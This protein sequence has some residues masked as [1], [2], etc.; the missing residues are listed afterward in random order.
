MT[1][2]RQGHLRGAARTAE[3]LSRCWDSAERDTGAAWQLA[4]RYHRAILNRLR[5]WRGIRRVRETQASGWLNEFFSLEQ[6]CDSK[7]LPEIFRSFLRSGL[8]LSENTSSRL[9]KHVLER[10][11]YVLRAAAEQALRDFSDA[12]PEAEPERLLNTKGFPSQLLLSDGLSAVWSVWY[13][14]QAIRSSLKLLLA[15]NPKDEYPEARAMKRHFILHL[16]GTNTG[17]T[18]AGFQRLK[19][20]PTGVYLAPLRLLALEAQETLLDAGI[21]CSLTTGEEEDRREGDTHVAA[22]AEKLDLRARYDAAVIDE[23]QMIADRERGYAWTRAILGVL[24]P[25]VH[26]C[27]A[28]EAKNLLIRLIESCG[29]SY[30]VEVHRRRTPLVCMS[31]TVDF[32]HLRP[33]DALISFSKVGVLS[34]GQGA[35]H[36]LRSPALC[37]AAQADGRFSRRAHRVCRR[38]GCHRHGTESADSPHPVYGDREV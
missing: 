35:R 10:Y 16:G 32:D 29:D 14:P 12:Q 31:H 22:T 4:E 9:T 2:Y 28:P 7:R 30:E 5:S 6:R 25:E 33:G 18:Y 19:S 15:L 38:H 36:Y 20:V 26:L 13:V 21:D 23:C 37:Y 24:A 34:A 11:P 17:K 27:A 1:G 8:Y 3:L